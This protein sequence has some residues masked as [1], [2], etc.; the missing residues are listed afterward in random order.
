MRPRHQLSQYGRFVR[1]LIDMV[2]AA[3]M[4]HASSFKIDYPVIPFPLF[5]LSGKYAASGGGRD[6]GGLIYR[7]LSFSLTLVNFPCYEV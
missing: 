7:E 5:A 4:V 2:D 3:M 6:N 1:F